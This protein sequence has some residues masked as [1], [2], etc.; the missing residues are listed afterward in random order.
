MMKSS[1]ATL[2]QLWMLLVVSLACL[3]QT[4]THAFVL[5]RPR[6]HVGGGGGGGLRFFASSV[7]STKKASLRLLANDDDDDANGENGSTVTANTT[8][9]SA[10]EEEDERQEKHEFL[11]QALDENVLFDSLPDEALEA[12]MDAFEQKEFR[13]GDVIFQQGDAC[14]NDHV[15]VVYEG[16]CAVYVDGK[17][18]PRP[19]D[20]LLPQTIFGD[21]GVMYDQPRAQTVTC[22]TKAVTLFCIPCQ[23]F[24]SIILNQRIVGENDSHDGLGGR[25]DQNNE[26]ELVELIDETIQEIAGIK[27]LYDG[28]IIKPYS[29]QRS[30]LWQR[31]TG[32]ILQHVALPTLVNMLWCLCVIL[33]VR[34]ITLGADA[35]LTDVWKAPNPATDPWISELQMVNKIWSYQQALTTFI[36]TFFLNQA[37]TFW[38]EIYD[39]GRRVQSRLNEFH[40]IVATSATRKTDGSYTAKAETFLNDVGQYSRLFHVLLWAATTRRFRILQTKQGMERMASRGLMNSKQLKVLQNLDLPEDQKHTACLE[41]MMIRTDG[42]IRDGTLLVSDVAHRQV[43]LT[44]MNELSCTYSM[45]NNKLN[46]RMPLAYT[47]IVQVL[48]DTFVWL[49]P[50]GLYAVLGTWSVLCVGLLTV[51]Y[52]GLLDLAKIFLDPLNNEDFCRN[53]V[54]MDIGVLIRESNGGSTRWKNGAE[55]LPF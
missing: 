32:T 54:Y 30:W 21:M 9:T 26:K 25:D 51:F 33:F 4:R 53:S 46:G 49:A 12:L 16:Q 45:I 28:A 38:R 39:I 29:P 5:A 17:L 42:A 34:Y 50:L 14:E 2:R 37:Y 8:A 41:W 19:Y 22:K 40:F 7:Q 31:F 35:W 43:L 44:T 13:Q 6:H 47:H 24:K 10:Q 52:A 11:R 27:T 1:Q 55:S 18:V 15:Y 36:L 23:D 20:R 3:G 48:V